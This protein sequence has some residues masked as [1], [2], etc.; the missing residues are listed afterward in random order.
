LFFSPTKAEDNLGKRKQSSLIA[1]QKLTT[2]TQNYVL[3]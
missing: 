1:S 3:D 2:K